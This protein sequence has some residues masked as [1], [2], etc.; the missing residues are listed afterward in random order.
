MLSSELSRIFNKPPFVSLKVFYNF[1]ELFYWLFIFNPYID[2]DC[3]AVSLLPNYSCLIK[4]SASFFLLFYSI[5]NLD[6]F[7]LQSLIFSS[8]CWFM[9]LILS[10]LSSLFFKSVSISLFL[11]IPI[12]LFLLFFYSLSIFCSFFKI[13]IFCYSSSIIFCY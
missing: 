4:L 5:F 10:I 12:I 2:V 3:K 8:I 7:S 6:I 9:L 1:L 11:L 13:T